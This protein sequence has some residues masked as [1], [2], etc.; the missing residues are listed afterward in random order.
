M[1]VLD[2]RRNRLEN[3]KYVNGLLR[4]INHFRPM[5]DDDG[6]IIGFFNYDRAV[7]LHEQF[8]FEGDYLE[9]HLGEDHFINLRIHKEVFKEMFALIPLWLEV[10]LRDN[11]D[12]I[13]A[14]RKW[15]NS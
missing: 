8:R 5:Y 1:R 14:F 2:T 9:H 4:G 11:W 3:M 7:F 6:N 10:I 15:M 13:C 12:L